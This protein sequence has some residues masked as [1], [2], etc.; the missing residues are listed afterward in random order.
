MLFKYLIYFFNTANE[1]QTQSTGI[2]LET[3]AEMK[4][5]VSSSSFLDTFIKF[6]LNYYSLEVTYIHNLQMFSLFY[7]SWVFKFPATNR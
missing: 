4:L 3:V 7:I 6:L 2:I 1:P 5:Q